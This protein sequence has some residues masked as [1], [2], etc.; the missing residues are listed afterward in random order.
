ML[1]NIPEI[2]IISTAK[3]ESNNVYHR[4]S[5]NH[6]FHLYILLGNIIL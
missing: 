3:S 6:I 1:L 2:N 5:H 4:Q